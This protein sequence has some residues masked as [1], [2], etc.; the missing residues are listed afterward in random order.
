MLRRIVGYTVSR[1][2]VEG[3]FGLRGIALASILGPNLFGLWSLFRLAI[4]Y[5]GFVG[6]TLNR[7]ME[8]KVAAAA[9]PQPDV[10]SLE[11]KHWAEITLGPTLSYGLLT[12]VI[13]L[14]A[15]FWPVEGLT[16]P[17]IVTIAATV[18]IERLWRYALTF[19][20]AAGLFQRFA[21]LE[22]VYSLL[23]LTLTLGLAL[24]WGLGGAIVGFFAATTASLGVAARRVPWRPR[25]SLTRVK[26][27]F[28]IG[29]PIGL[30][31]VA[32]GVLQSVDR[33]LV[34]AFVG[35]TALGTYAFAIS[36]SRAGIH[37]AMIA[38]NVILTDVYGGNSQ[39]DGGQA[40][41][42]IMGR[43]LVAFTTLLPLFAGFAAL[44]L[45]PVILMLLPQYRAGIV[46]AQIFMFI[47]VLQ[48]I[49]NLSIM[50]I[51]AEGRQQRMP[52]ISLGA[53]TLNLCL[54]SLALFFG[55]GLQG[56][57]L[58]AF[59]ARAAYA[60]A[61]TRLLT[62]TKP[63][64]TSYGSLTESL[65]PTIWCA[66]AVLTIQQIAPALEWKSLA[67]ALLLYLVCL[68][69]LTNLVRSALESFR[70]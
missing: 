64:T 13:T 41:R 43:S 26:Q 54:A 15:F 70:T 69:P 45:Q 62:T 16:N 42:V 24:I 8:V 25:W 65:A 66:A 30:T 44:T 58:G 5:F 19:T 28:G 68:L 10:I 1:S 51:V 23:Q 56:V 50:G 32:T 52:L 36:L 61:I 7:G 12:G 33:L 35:M 60:A 21:V 31:N 57:A 40:G 3:L 48:G 22:F 37:L 38:R 18:I 39:G 2:A 14:A 59:L 11:Q 47:G 9:S 29:F 17:L 67:F 55:L 53:I 6:Q 49:V 4:D 34:G 63:M 20:R 27:V 46:V